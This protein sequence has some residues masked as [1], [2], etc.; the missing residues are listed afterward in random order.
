MNP[1]DGANA[2]Q[3]ESHWY[4]PQTEGADHEQMESEARAVQEAYLRLHSTRDVAA[5]RRLLEDRGLRIGE[6]TIRRVL[7]ELPAGPGDAGADKV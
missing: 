2:G 3:P 6:A 7:G 5:I 1:N 4:A